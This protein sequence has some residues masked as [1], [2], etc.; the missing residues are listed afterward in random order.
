[1][2]STRLVDRSRLQP[3]RGRRP[4]TL[5]GPSVEQLGER[6]ALL[7]G[8]LA[9]ALETIIYGVHHPGCWFCVGV[10]LMPF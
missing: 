1:M 2:R 9:G 4:G 8:L 6:I 7:F 5:A 3:L 10:P